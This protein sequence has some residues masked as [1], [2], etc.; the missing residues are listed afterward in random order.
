MLE[1]VLLLTN[2]YEYVKVFV[3]NELFVF[4][5]KFFFFLIW[6]EF[7]S[8]HVVDLKA[9]SLIIFQFDGNDVCLW[10]FE[11]QMLLENNVV[12]WI[13]SCVEFIKRD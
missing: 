9:I 6:K 13:W 8:Q 7:S 10:K 1:L 11:I 5:I 12:F 2:V 3:Y 4:R